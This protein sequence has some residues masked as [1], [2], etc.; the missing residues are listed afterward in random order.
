L[1]G[2]EQM[3]RLGDRPVAKHILAVLEQSKGV[4]FRIADL[5]K[6]MAKQGWRHSGNAM[7]DNCKLLVEQELIVEREQYYGIPKDGD[8]TVPESRPKLHLPYMSRQPKPERDRCDKCHRKF[9]QGDKF[10]IRAIGGV[11]LYVCEECH[12]QKTTSAPIAPCLF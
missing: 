4:G 1:I 9:E 12:E 6:E 5:V 11:K 10:Y 2:C 3:P 8:I 7:G